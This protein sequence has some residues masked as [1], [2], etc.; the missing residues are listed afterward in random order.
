M[1]DARP[2]VCNRSGY[3]P[4]QSEHMSYR[5]AVLH[6]VLTRRNACNSI[7]ARTFLPSDHSVAKLA[8]AASQL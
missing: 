2:Y 3:A 8:K 1:S 7:A 6:T 5:P 4:K